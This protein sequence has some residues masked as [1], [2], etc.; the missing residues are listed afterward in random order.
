MASASKDKHKVI[1]F[2]IKS[3]ELLKHDFSIPS[4]PIGK[5]GEYNF[6][7]GIEQKIDYEKKFFIVILNIDIMSVETVDLKLGSASIG[8]VYSFDDFDSA[9]NADQDGK[10]HIEE[11]II[12]TLNS[13]SISTSRGVLSQLL[14]GTFLHG[15]ILPVVDPKIFKPVDDK[16]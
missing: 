13:I 6:N 8:C 15:A 1:N 10:P 14:R 11:S 5:N 7:L 12:H 4:V 9:M 2:Q 16:H 3:V